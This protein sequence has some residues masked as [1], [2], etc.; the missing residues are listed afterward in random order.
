MKTIITAILCLL[1]FQ[2]TAQLV[3]V[4]GRVVDEQNE[5]LNGVAVIV[6]GTKQG[7]QTDIDG[8]FSIEARIGQQLAFS[9]MGTGE[10]IVSVKSDD[11][12]NVVLKEKLEEIDVVTIYGIPKKRKTMSTAITSLGPE[13]IENKAQPD[14]LRT[15]TGKVPGTQMIPISG[16]LGTG[17]NFY[18]RSKS[19]INGDNSPL[20][21]VDG[22]PFNTSTNSIAGFESGIE[23]SSRGLDLDP[24]NIAKVEVLRGLG[25]TVLYGQEG[26]NGVVLITTKTG[27]FTGQGM[28]PEKTFSERYLEAQEEARTALANERTREEL[29]I[30]GTYQYL[31]LEL[32]GSND[33]LDRFREMEKELGTDPSFYFELYDRFKRIDPGFAEKVLK[34]LSEVNTKD[35]AFMKASAFKLEQANRHDLAIKLYQQILRLSA[36]DLQTRRNLALAYQALNKPELALEQYNAILTRDLP[37]EFS[38]IIGTELSRFLRTETDLARQAYGLSA[39][40]IEILEYDMRIVIDWNRDDTDIDLQVIDPNLEVAT[41]QAAKTKAGGRLLSNNA[42][43][44]GTEVFQIAQL[45]SGSYYLKVAYNNEVPDEK[46]KDIFVKLTI[47]RNYGRENQTAEV[48]LIKISDEADLQLMDRIAAF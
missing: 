7:V 30:P 26:R 17:V 6:R 47:Y 12:L 4:E 5:P 41:P 18:I 8:N 16:A 20:F 43:G 35:M 36:H 9:Y 29:G 42:K 23:S 32:L 46:L 10:E 33:K 21:V 31:V 39:E 1:T 27:S 14:L 25:A 19:S 13:D 24:N 44:N 34:A 15:I 2:L 3:T 22:M 45:Q 48:K 37:D 11:P 38:R 28:A 40:D